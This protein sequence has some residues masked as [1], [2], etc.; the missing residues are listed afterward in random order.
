MKIFLFLSIFFLS[1]FSSVRLFFSRANA[2]EFEETT[3]DLEVVEPTIEED[4]ISFKENPI[5]KQWRNVSIFNTL[6]GHQAAITSLAFSPDGQILVSGGSQNDRSIYVWDANTGRRIRK[7]RIQ[8]GR[9]TSI[10]I[11]SEGNLIVSSSDVAGVSL[12]EWQNR[13]RRE[14]ERW[15]VGHN[16]NI[17]SSIVTPDDRV[18]ITGGLDG[19]RLWDLQAMKPI[20][21]LVRFD[22]VTALAIHPNGYI[23]ASAS[24]DGTLKLWNLRTSELLEEIKAH[25]ETINTLTFTPDGGMLISGSRDR[26][27][28]LWRSGTGELLK[29]LE[30]TGNVNAIA[31]HPSGVLLASGSR[32]GIRLW[33]IETG[34]IINT[35]TG[36]SDWVEALAFSPDGSILASGGFDNQVRLWQPISPELSE[37]N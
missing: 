12:W 37:D 22:V 32:S 8:N 6:A 20:Y 31:V 17:L 3:P 13:R 21:T 5:I 4:S 16:H 2:T 26:S 27:I 35:F 34:E 10:A 24:Q 19:I 28:K 30:S 29:T 7:N 14:N 25:E 36:Y 15:V 18:L 11:A 23:L 33:D 9:V 1:S